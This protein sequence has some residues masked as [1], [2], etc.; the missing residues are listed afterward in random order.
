MN[1]LSHKLIEE[2]LQEFIFQYICGCVI[3]EQTREQIC[4][5]QNCPIQLNLPYVEK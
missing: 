4:F 1:N 3:L 5:C 2:E